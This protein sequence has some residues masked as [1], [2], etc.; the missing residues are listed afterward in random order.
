MLGKFNVAKQIKKLQHE[1]PNTRWHAAMKLVERKQAID[2]AVPVLIPFLHHPETWVRQGTAI[3][4]GR[5]EENAARAVPELIKLLEDKE[6]TVQLMAVR[7]LRR[8]GPPAKSAVPGIERWAAQGNDRLRDQ[9]AR[10][11]A[12]ILGKGS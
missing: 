8:I 3:V 1:D 5:A 9:A 2:Q 11:I 10:A 12:A 6:L 7:A 4:L